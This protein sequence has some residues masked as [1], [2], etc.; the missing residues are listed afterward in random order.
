MRCPR[1]SRFYQVKG[2]A[3]WKRWVK[4]TLAL[5]AANFVKSGIGVAD[6]QGPLLLPCHAQPRFF[7][8]RNGNRLP[9]KSYRAEAYFVNSRENTVKIVEF[10]PLQVRLRVKL[11]SPDRLILNQNHHPQWVTS[12]GLVQKWNGLVSV[13]LPRTGTYEITLQFHPRRMIVGLIVS[14]P[15]FLIVLGKAIRIGVSP[16]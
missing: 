2:V 12:E 8:A 3:W 6:W 7:I 5:N 9:N 14:V 1:V 4:R 10:T 15:L 11:A 13:V 16:Q